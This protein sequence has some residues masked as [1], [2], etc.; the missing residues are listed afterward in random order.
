MSEGPRELGR[1]QILDAIRA[2]GPVPRIELA[3]MTGI[4]RA[5]VTTITAEMLAH[6]LIEEVAPAD[7]T[8]GSGRG[9][10]RVDLR[11]RGAAH[12]LAGIK[13]TS[14]HLSI[15]LMDFDGTERSLGRVPLP[16]PVMS[17]EALVDAL[18]DALD[19]RA[20]HIGLR[21]SDISAIGIGLPGIVNATSGRV[22]WSPGL[23]KRN[24]DLARMI[25]DRLDLPA[26]IDNDANLVALAE[27]QFGQ[28]RGRD[29]FV[30]V[31]IENGVGMG[32]I[33]NGALYRG[34]HGCGAE[35][36]HIKVQLDGA[37][38]RCG[39]RGCLEAYV[40]NYAL[41]REAALVMGPS[42]D[43]QMTLTG[44][45]DAARAD[46]P[47]AKSI[48]ERAGRI[49]AMGLANLINLF[50]PE[51]I[52]LA[53]EEHQLGHLHGPA[54]LDR[55]TKQSLQVDRAPP[56]IVVHGWGARMW[57][58]GA[59]AIARHQVTELALDRMRRDAM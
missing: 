29:T 37:L 1:R 56:D 48:L 47:M 42:A 13:I 12:L 33:L 39:Q 24:V 50:D 59:A 28:G 6:G 19:L 31:T 18:G 32:L 22:L 20:R 21:R 43:P 57:A 4:S 46:D 27:Q 55:I 30:V 53:G 11:I 2:H 26:L 5:T 15:L 58:V 14:D 8:P 16:A 3:R 41:L 49:F 10:P 40:A 52:I 34:A 9:R 7:D 38:C 45:Q 25:G 44:L 17:P 35:F 54:L 51:L 23:T 36:G